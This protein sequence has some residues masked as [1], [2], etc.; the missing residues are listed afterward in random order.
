MCIRDRWIIAGS[1]AAFFVSQLV[2]VTI[3]HRIKFFT[4]EKNICC[5]LYTSDAA[6]ERSSVDLGGSRIIKKQTL[7]EDGG[8]TPNITKVIVNIT[9]QV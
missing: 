8:M 9:I 6:D 4:G 5:L 3:F 1:I 2:D 7:E